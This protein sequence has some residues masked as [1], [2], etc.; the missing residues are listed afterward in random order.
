MH[1]T[2]TSD[3]PGSCPI[4]G[5]KLVR[6]PVS[7]PPAQPGLATIALSPEQRV[8]AN[9]KTMR[10]STGQASNELI[11]TGRVTF[12]ERR[13]AQV[14]SYTAGRIERLFVNFTGDVV[15]RGRPVAT[16]YSPDLYSTQQEYLLALANRER[17][18]KSGFA[19]ARSAA[20]DLVESTRRRLQLFGMSGAQIDALTKGAKP[21]YTTTIVSPFSGV[22]T[23]KLVVPQQSVMAG[24]PLLEIADLSVVWVD[25]NV[26]ESDLPRVAIG[27][28][29]SVTTPALPG[30]DVPGTISFVDPVVN[31]ETRS[32]R[33]RI[34]IP[35]RNFR[36]KPDMYVTVKIFAGAARPAIMIPASALVDRG[37]RQ[38]V[39]VEVGSGTFAPREVRAG[40]RS[41]DRVEIL[42]G[43]DG[44]ETIV[45]DGAFLL[46]S[47]AQLRSAQGS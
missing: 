9:V 41:S 24:E 4:C 14:T 29:V 18:R 15:E 13:V 47:E 28:R 21:L 10:V 20:D 40:A 17:M 8:L 27:Q 37:L 30:Y 23:R 7:P 25:A 34:D 39:W 1:P 35:N 32:T 6:R 43:L 12:D 38:F 44:S 42:S 11:T 16:I 19:Q 5:M 36:L 26:Y 31:P 22:V 33:V 45:V 3:R 2:V 46:E